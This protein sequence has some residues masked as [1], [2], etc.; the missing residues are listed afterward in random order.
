M[1]ERQVW[2]QVLHPGGWQEVESLPLF[3]AAQGDELCVWFEHA[4]FFD[5]QQVPVLVR[6]YGTG[7][8]IQ[9]MA[10]HLFS[11]TQG[12]YVWHLYTINKEM[13]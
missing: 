5:R 7:H 11:C 9:Y 6:V 10:T 1:T 2:K 12:P 8:P 4:Q 3:F 13:L